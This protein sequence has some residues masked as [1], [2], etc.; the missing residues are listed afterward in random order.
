MSKTLKRDKPITVVTRDNIRTLLPHSETKVKKSTSTII[1]SDD[2]QRIKVFLLN[3]I[4]ECIGLHE[5][6][7][8]T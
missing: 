6:C 4:I 1:N 7:S 3:L 8:S 5:L 2:L